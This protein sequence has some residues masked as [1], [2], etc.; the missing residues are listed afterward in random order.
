MSEPLLQIRNLSKQFETSRGPV[1]AVNDVSF[2]ISRGSITGL[3]GESGSGKTTHWAAL[4]FAWSSHRKARPFS[5]AK[6]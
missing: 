3:V 1:H 4:S 6:T 5:K 2:D